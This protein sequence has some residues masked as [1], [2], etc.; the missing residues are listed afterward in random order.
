MQ[1]LLRFISSYSRAASLCVLPLT[2]ALMVGCNQ[3]SEEQPSDPDMAPATTPTADVTSDLTLAIVEEGLST[4]ESA[5]FDPASGDVFI[6]NIVIDPNIEE[7][8]RY[9]TEDGT[10]FITRIGADGTVKQ[11]EW[12]K[13]DLDPLL[14]GPKGIAIADGNIYICDNANLFVAPLDE[15]KPVEKIDIPGSE[16]LNDVCVKDGVV[17]TSDTKRALVYKIDGENITEIK[18]PASTNG[19]TFLGDKL[20]ALSFETPDLYL[21]DVTGEKPAEGL[22]LTTLYKKGDGIEPLE[23]G[24][25]LITDFEGGKVVHLAADLK[26]TTVIYDAGPGSSLADIGIDRSS[27]KIFIPSVLTDKLYI[28]DYKKAMEKAASTPEQPAEATEPAE[29]SEE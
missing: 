1:N 6:S 27:G 25:L 22:G 17:Y 5:D 9:W 21:L 4:P 12:R 16:Y 28:V 15:T 13:A 29:T 24:S 23:D 2:F 18:G 11:L 26:T 7:P 19:I 3:P 10:G 14:H 20:Y 8:T